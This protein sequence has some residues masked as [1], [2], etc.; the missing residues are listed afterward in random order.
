MTVP[1]S[2]VWKAMTKH[3]SGEEKLRH[4]TVTET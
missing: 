2:P 3:L 1:V 4:V